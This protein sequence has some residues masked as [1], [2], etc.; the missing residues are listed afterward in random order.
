MSQFVLRKT[1]TVDPDPRR[2]VG[3]NDLILLPAGEHL[4]VIPE[5]ELAQLAPAHFVDAEGSDELPEDWRPAERQE[6]DR[7]LERRRAAALEER[8]ADKAAR[9]AKAGA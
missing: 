4:E 3:P 5:H 1:V 7:E 8:L 9:D 6:A 2:E